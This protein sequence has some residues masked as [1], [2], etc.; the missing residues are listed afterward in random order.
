VAAA[1]NRSSPG[2][3]LLGIGTGALVGRWLIT[4]PAVLLDAG[5]VTTAGHRMGS[6]VAGGGI[7]GEHLGAD[8]DLGDR[9]GGP[10]AA[11]RAETP[12]RA[13]RPPTSRVWGVS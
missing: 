5:P 1:V 9:Q 11:R 12:A 7:G 4:P 10:D 13:R 2:R 6:A 3:S 8:V